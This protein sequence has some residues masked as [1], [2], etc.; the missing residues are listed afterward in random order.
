M[1]KMFSTGLTAGL[2]GGLA[3]IVTAGHALAASLPVDLNGVEFAP[4]RFQL[5]QHGENVGE[6]FYSMERR[7]GEI[8]IHDGTTMLPDIRESGT[9][10]IDADTLLPKRVVIDGDFSRTVLD[11]DLAFDGRKGAGVYRIKRPSETEKTDRPFEIDLPEGAV[12][13][14]SIFGLMAGLPVREG[15]SF[16]FQWFNELGGALADAE[17]VVEGR[18]TIEVPAGVFETYEIKLNAQPANVVYLTVEAPHKLVRID[19]P[20][21][22]MKF[23]RLPAENKA[24]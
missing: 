4:V 18:K 24:E 8:V 14:A 13:R 9:L 22:D 17:L 23:E 11:I 20:G 5:L 1:K 10:V 7:D 19:V 12:A 2:A 3:A 21:Q 6:M 16:A 15:A